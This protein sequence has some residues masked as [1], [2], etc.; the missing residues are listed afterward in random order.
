MTLRDGNR[1]VHENN[2][3]LAVNS[4]TTETYRILF[5]ERPSIVLEVVNIGGI[6][7]DEEGPIDPVSVVTVS[8]NKEVNQESF[9][10]DA[11]KLTRAGQRV[12]VSD[13]KVSRIA[14]SDYTLSL[15]NATR[16]E[17]YYLLTVDASS[18][19]DV[20]GY[21]GENGKSKG[22]LQKGETF[23]MV[24]LLEAEDGG[25]AIWPVPVRGEMNLS[26]DFSALKRLTIHDTTGAIMGQWHDLTAV[27]NGSGRRSV[28]LRIEGVPTGVMIVTA[29]T[30]TGYIFTRRLLFLP[31]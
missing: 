9:S 23:A 13:V 29:V 2:L 3:H 8:F 14:P 4:Q 19:K 27:T 24:D 26:G 5:E 1:P 16:Y 11:L 6:P 12:D 7:S 10:T 25:M 21:E 20:D 28:S 30:D 17:G 15:G 31:Q 22:W 18:I